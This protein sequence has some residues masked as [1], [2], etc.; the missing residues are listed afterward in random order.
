VLRIRHVY[1]G[2]RIL[3]FVHPGSRISYPGSWILKVDDENSR[4]RIHYLEAWICGSGSTPKIHGSATLL[5][6][7]KYGTP[8]EKIKINFNSAKVNGVGGKDETKDEAMDQDSGAA[9]E[10]KPKA[11]A[12]A[13][14]KAEEEAATAEAC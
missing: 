7:M 14:P 8:P 9:E 3:I 13:K 5:I 4:V 6:L 12:A 2:S 1:P 10:S 11:E